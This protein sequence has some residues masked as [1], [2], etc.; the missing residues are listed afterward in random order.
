MEN[1]K[2][3]IKRVKELNF[4]IGEYTIFGSGP[5]A[6]RNLRDSH[7]VDI[8][9]SEKIWDKYKNNPEWKSIK[10]VRD[11]KVIEVLE[12]NN[13]EIGKSWGP[14]KW[15]IQK[16]IDENDI[17]DGMP[18]VKL[19]EVLKWKKLSNRNKDKKDIEILEKLKINKKNK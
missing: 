8:I 9:V 18:F 15:N 14:G 3:L 13:I 10:F 17:I 11:N 7:D 19:D 6:A 2:N 5:M 16:L 4:P 12:N 1:F